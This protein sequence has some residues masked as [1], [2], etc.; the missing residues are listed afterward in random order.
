MNL[1]AFDVGGTQIKYGIVT[2]NGEVI[3]AALFDTPKYSGG[4]GLVSVLIR[5]AR[6]LMAKYTVAGVAISTFGLVDAKNG[7]II[8]AAEAIDGYTGTQLKAE[9][10]LALQLPVAVDNDVNCVAMAEGWQGAAKGVGNYIAVAIGTGI[11][12][13]IVID[14]R[15][16]RGH[17]A[18]AGEWGYM[19]IDGLI[20]ED[21]ASM[22]GLQN[23]V[24]QSID[25][26]EPLDGKAI[27]AL[28]DQ[29]NTQ[30][31]AIVQAWFKLLARGLANLIYA[32]NP[33]RIVI[34]GGITAR[35][36]QFLHELTSAVQTELQPDFQEMT[37][38][39]LASAGNH[40]GMIGAS[41]NWLNT[42]QTK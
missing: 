1:I 5:L 19:R 27:F 35:G 22:R 34:G 6:E 41:K 9:L 17:R 23:S 3:S 4:A 32:F 14:E 13:G 31:Q 30:I 10:E 42:Y 36:A 37:Q 8:G 26:A 18:A 15:I 24:N 40:A 20:W 16:Y 21:H 2:E 38:I 7:V 29:G 12:G 28:Y 39:V 33:E 11:G 25:S